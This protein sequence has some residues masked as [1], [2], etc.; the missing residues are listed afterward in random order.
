MG[1]AAAV[2]RSGKYITI[3]NKVAAGISEAEE[4]DEARECM[5]PTRPESYIETKLPGGLSAQKG[6]IRCKKQ[7]AKRP[8]EVKKLCNSMI[9]KHT[10]LISRSKSRRHVTNHT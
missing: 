10:K 5:Y 9:W 7:E 1:Y 8:R 6:G 3:R 4:L 2:L